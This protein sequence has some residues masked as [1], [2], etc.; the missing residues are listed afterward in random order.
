M[1]YINDILNIAYLNEY[2]VADGL[3]SLQVSR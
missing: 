1:Y 2:N 3:Q